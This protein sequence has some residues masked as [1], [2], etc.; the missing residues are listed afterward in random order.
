MSTPIT[1]IGN[2]TRDPEL[3]FAP[4]G[5]AIT[6]V[7]VAVNTRKKEGD[8]WVDGDPSF[9]NVTCFGTLAE[10]VAEAVEKGTRLVVSGRIEQQHYE[11]DGEK[12]SSYEVIADEIGPS[13]RWATAVV[14]KQV[15]Q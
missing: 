13:L 3:Q 6:K 9:Y 8:Q 1:V 11:K 15:S 5:T 7:G 4:S 14:T 10:N 2:A 12:E